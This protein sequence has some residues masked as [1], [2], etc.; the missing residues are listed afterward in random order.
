MYKTNHGI[1]LIFILAG[2]PRED[3]GGDGGLETFLEVGVVAGCLVNCEF[4]NGEF[5]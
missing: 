4:V 5:A 1:N 2:V 3:D